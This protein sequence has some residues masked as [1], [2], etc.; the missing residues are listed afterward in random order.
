M[1]TRRRESLFKS[2]SLDELLCSI[3]MSSFFTR[4]F[5]DRFNPTTIR[6]EV[7]ESIVFLVSMLLFAFFQSCLS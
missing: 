6:K 5:F 3:F 7:I 2:N 1:E 4:C